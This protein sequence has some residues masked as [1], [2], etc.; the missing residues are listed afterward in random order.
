M[1]GARGGR[2]GAPA[3]APAVGHGARASE[4]AGAAGRG[5][6]RGGAR[7]LTRRL[8]AVGPRPVRDFRR[9]LVVDDRG[10]SASHI[11]HSIDSICRSTIEVHA[12]HDETRGCGPSS[13]EMSPTSALGGGRGGWGGGGGGG[14]GLDR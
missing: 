3:A 11:F 10:R 14:G 1:G 4:A 5:T 7:I 13:T 12:P 8:R 2:A 9:R 6:G